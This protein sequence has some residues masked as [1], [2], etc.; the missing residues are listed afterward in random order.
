MI[1]ISPARSLHI[2]DP[3][4]VYR[5]VQWATGRI[6]AVSLRELIVS[7]QFDLVGVYVHSEAKAGKDAGELCGLDPVGVVATCDIAEIIALMPDC[8]VANPEGANV[9]DV[10]RFLEAGINVATS[11]VDYIDPE[12]MDQDVRRR[13]EAACAK[14]N[15]SIHGTGSSPGFSS[16]SMPLVMTSMSRRMDRM[17]IDEFA[18][19]P[20]S[21]PDVQVLQMGFGRDAGGEFNPHLLQ[22]IGHGFFQSLNVIAA[23]LGIV[24]DRITANGETAHALERH[25]LPGGTPMEKG[26]VAAQRISII[27]EYAGKP[28]I[29][30]RITWHTGTAVDADWELRKAG[31]RLRID[32]PTPIEANVGYPEMSSEQYSLAMAGLTAYRVINAVPFICAAEPG[33][34]TSIEMPAIV[35]RLA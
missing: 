17:I 27:A 33:I 6:G 25:I 29:T 26:T 34:R 4:K 24:L 20:A 22:H 35:P 2:P 9:D 5:V 12:Y 32:G 18:D 19:I 3:A 23:G 8:V 10:C 14:G 21:C 31:W 13:V 7:S 15:S 28:L 30:F 11:R 1:T 16:E